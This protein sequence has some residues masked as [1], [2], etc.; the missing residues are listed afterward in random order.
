MN[1]IA[2]EVRKQ[3]KLDIGVRYEVNHT[4]IKFYE[5]SFVCGGSP[6]R[7]FGYMLLNKNKIK[8]AID[9]H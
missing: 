3:L 9:I 7:L 1:A 2:E 6:L 8:K 5:N 4:Y